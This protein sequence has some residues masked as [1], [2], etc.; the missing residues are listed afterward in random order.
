MIDEAPCQCDG[1]WE[2]LGFGEQPMESLRI[3]FAGDRL[4]GTGIDVVG[5]FT[6]AGT[7]TRD[8][9]VA[10][11][12]QYLRQHAVEYLGTHDGEGSLAGEWHVGGF[13]GRWRIQVRR[14]EGEAEIQEF[15]PPG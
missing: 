14:L 7:I 11:I 2:Q 5:P 3:A 12:K 10:I 4:R 1:W 9:R 6:L 15:Q 13:R 8:G